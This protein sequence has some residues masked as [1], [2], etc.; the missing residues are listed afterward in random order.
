MVIETP[1]SKFY[2]AASQ[3]LSDWKTNVFYKA[4]RMNARHMKSPIAKLEKAAQP[5]AYRELFDIVP[6]IVA[7]PP[8]AEL[9]FVGIPGSDGGKWTCGINT[10]T[11]P[12]HVFS[13]GSNGNYQFEEDILKNTPCAV[14]TF[15]CTMKNRGGGKVLHSSRHKFY[16]KCLGSE[17]KAA[18]DEDFVSMRGAKA[19]AEAE[20][21]D[22]LK[23][24]I[25]GFEFDVLGAP[26]DVRHKDDLPRQIAME[27][28]VQHVYW[29]SSYYG[30]DGLDNLLYPR[31]PHITAPELALFFMHLGTLGYAVAYQEKNPACPH[32]SEFLLL[33]V[34]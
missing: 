11:A 21:V 10:L 13:I 3:N 27:V 6:A 2:A 25:E 29:G 8:G 31:A 22:F 15:D 7:C 9:A 16:L 19:L 32:C 33:R 28:H 1:L 20:T 17:E 34:E 18:S 12:C 14:S 23:I 5:A 26:F 30:A 4:E 24:D